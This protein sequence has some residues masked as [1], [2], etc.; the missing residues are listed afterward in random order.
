MNENYYD[1]KVIKAKVF[2]VGQHIYQMTAI[3]RTVG[4][5]SLII[6]NNEFVNCSKL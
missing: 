2:R 1:V 5:Y 6:D 4:G 3:V